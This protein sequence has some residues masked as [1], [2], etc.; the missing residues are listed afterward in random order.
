M[1]TSHILTVLSQEPVK[2][3]RGGRQPL[4]NTNRNTLQQNKISNHPK[5]MLHTSAAT[6]RT[7]THAAYQCQTKPIKTKIQFNKIKHAPHQNFT[8]HFTKPLQRNRNRNRSQV[9]QRNTIAIREQYAQQQQEK[10]L[11]SN[12]KSTSKIKIKFTNHNK[13]SRQENDIKQSNKKGIIID[14]LI[15]NNRIHQKQITRDCNY[16]YCL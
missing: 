8:H 16:Q 14:A 12:A 3:R 2:K 1:L 9:E 7:G 4:Q 11:E 10:K 6:S 13:Q 5:N 15:S